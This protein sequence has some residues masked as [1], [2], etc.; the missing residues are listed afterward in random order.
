MGRGPGEWARLPSP[1]RQ[2]NEA[3][4]AASTSAATSARATAWV[5]LSRA[6]SARR[7]RAARRRTA[8]T[9]SAMSAMAASEK[10]AVGLA[11]KAEAG[12]EKSPTA[13]AA[14]TVTAGRRIAG[15]REALPSQTIPRTDRPPNNPSRVSIGTAGYDTLVR[16]A[17]PSSPGEWNG[18]GRDGCSPALISVVIGLV[19]A[20]RIDAEIFGLLG[21]QPGQLGAELFEMQRRHLLVEVLGQDIDLVFVLA[22]IGPQFELRQHLVGEG[23]AHH[24]RGMAGAAAEIDQP[25]LGEDDEA[26]AVGE[27]D[28]VN[29]RLDLFPGIVAQRVDLD[30][31]VE[32]ADVADDG[33]VLHP[34][35]VVEGDDVDIPGRGDEDVADRGGVLH[36]RHLI[37][38]HRRLQHADRIDLGHHDSGP[39][40]PQAPRRPLADIAEAAD[41]GDLA[42]HHDVGGALDAVDQALAAAIKIV[43]FRLGDAVVDIDR[44]DLEL[45]RLHHL[46]EPVDAG[47]RLLGD[48]FDVLQ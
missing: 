16:P 2:R 5:A 45:A 19:G 24:E 14:A 22:G 35:H 28:L 41:H 44:G 34:P 40:A 21:R 4:G 46:V 13:A 20:L 3:E 26:L 42:G 29:L 48:A 6:P 25:S 8:R 38:F 47:R 23:G 7:R 30:L 31:A 36:R 1:T 15:H 43:E 17:P 33:A 32:M 39:L 10:R 18:S 37:A 12:W 27:D 9:A 11:S